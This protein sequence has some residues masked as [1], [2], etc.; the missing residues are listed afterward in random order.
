V[1]PVG[2]SPIPDRKPLILILLRLGL[3]LWLW[4]WLLL[5]LSR[6]LTLWRSATGHSKSF[7]IRNRRRTRRVERLD[8]ATG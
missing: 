6:P 4:L 7:V 8:E 2:S 3:M 1:G 5:T